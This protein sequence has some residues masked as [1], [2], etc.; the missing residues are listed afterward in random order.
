MDEVYEVFYERVQDI[1]AEGSRDT[2]V[3]IESQADIAS[4]VELVI[5]IVPPAHME[6]VIEDDT[7][8]EFNDRTCGSHAEEYDQEVIAQGLEDPDG[9]IKAQSVYGTKRTCQKAP[10]DKLA[11]GNAIVNNFYDPADEAVDKEHQVGF[12]KRIR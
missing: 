8:Y 1:D 2:P 12:N 5:G 4:E 6:S 9:G 10:V 11:F 3:D 7:G